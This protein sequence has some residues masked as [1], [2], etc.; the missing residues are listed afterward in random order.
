L[1]LFQIF[2]NDNIHEFIHV[3]ASSRNKYFILLCTF[4]KILCR[5]A[6]VYFKK[7][8]ELCAEIGRNLKY[9]IICIV[10]KLGLFVWVLLLF[11]LYVIVFQS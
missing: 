4:Y 3:V 5:I 11:L 7:R 8:Q 1:V 6:L 9:V 10:V 2:L